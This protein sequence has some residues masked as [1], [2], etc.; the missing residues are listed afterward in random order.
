MSQ[1]KIAENKNKMEKENAMIKRTFANIE[2]KLL[3]TCSKRELYGLEK[4]LEER[5]TLNKFKRLEQ[6]V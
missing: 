2:G 5:V 6:N 4:G 3:D 1:D